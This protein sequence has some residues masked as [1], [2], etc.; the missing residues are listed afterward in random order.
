MIRIAKVY[1]SCHITYNI[2]SFT[3]MNLSSLGSKLKM[4]N[5]EK[6]GEVLTKFGKISMKSI[7]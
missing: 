4:K 7:T 1:E 2:N 5:G 3:Y 6:L